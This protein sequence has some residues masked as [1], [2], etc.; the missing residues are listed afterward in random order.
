MRPIALDRKNW[1]FIG[2]NTAGECVACL[3]SLIESAKLNG[4]DA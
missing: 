2:S 4:R 3:M 1:S